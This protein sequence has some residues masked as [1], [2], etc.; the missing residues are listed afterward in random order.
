MVDKYI[1]NTDHNGNKRVFGGVVLLVTKH[2]KYRVAWKYATRNLPARSVR[3]QD[4]S[5]T[6]LYIS[7]STG[8]E[9]MEEALEIIR[10]MS[11]GPEILIGDL[12]SRHITW[13]VKSNSRRR[14]VANWAA[15][16]KWRV[17]EPEAPTLGI[18]NV[19]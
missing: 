9:E 11:R 17:G 8:K 16:I 10:R 5:V 6:R 13:D 12:N 18:N 2:L 15:R 19:G 3:V 14:L 4:V 1:I 7:S